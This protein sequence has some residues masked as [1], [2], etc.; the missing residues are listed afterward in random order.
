MPDQGPA[1]SGRIHH[2]QRRQVLVSLVAAAA[3]LATTAGSAA[4]AAG[5][6]EP[7]PLTPLTGLT[8]LDA[9]VTIEVDGTVNGKPTQGD[10]TAQLDDHRPGNQPDRRDR[11]PARRCR[12]PGGRL[13]RE[14]LPA[15][16]GQ[17]LL[18]AGGHVRGARCPHRRVHQAHGRQATA[19]L[20]QLSPRPSWRS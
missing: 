18:R 12:G 2:P 17:R 14:A 3:I 16:E 15:Q 9:A 13:G 6:S 4:G 1:M 10:L 8:A 11:Q 20:E 7:I 19:A 5:P